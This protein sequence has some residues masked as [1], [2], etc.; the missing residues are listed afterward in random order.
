MCC[1]TLEAETMTVLTFNDFRIKP[2][3]YY[4]HVQSILSKMMSHAD[5]ESK[6]YHAF[7]LAEQV[8]KNL[9]Q[10][11]DNFVHDR[12]KMTVLVRIKN[13]IPSLCSVKNIGK[14]F[15]SSLLV[16]SIEKS[17]KGHLV[18]FQEC[19]VFIPLLK[20]DSYGIAQPF[21]LNEITLIDY[22]DE[23]IL[24]IVPV[25]ESSSQTFPFKVIEKDKT[26]H[27]KAHVHAYCSKAGKKSI[28]QSFVQTQTPETSIFFNFISNADTEWSEFT[29][30]KR[31]AA[32]VISESSDNMEDII[33]K[34]GPKYS[35]NIIDTESMGVLTVDSEEHCYLRMHSDFSELTPN[36]DELN[37]VH[38]M[39]SIHRNLTQGLLSISRVKGNLIGNLSSIDISRLSGYLKEF[40]KVCPKIL[41]RS[42]S[43]Q[44]R[45]KR[46]STSISIH[47]NVSSASFQTLGRRLSLLGRRSSMKL[48]ALDPTQAPPVRQPV[49]LPPRRGT[50][51][52]LLSIFQPKPVEVI[53]AI[54][55][56][57]AKKL[58][59]H[60][61]RFEFAYSFDYSEKV[62]KVYDGKFEA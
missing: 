31:E 36:D 38:D 56:C 4:I 34:I 26:I 37:S 3:Q 54:L 29:N 12:I 7:E 41:R 16:T 62:G 55:K 17:A 32:L 18:L 13:D 58:D 33:G 10:S 15:I 2:V 48:D 21:P 46:G 1:D 20:N 24:T 61:S 43:K 8:S 47:S 27:F 53:S 28:V 6:Q 22:L 51:H 9:I 35:K 60:L 14:L 52:K 25:V 57:V 5:P 50:V 45:H 39:K 30:W 42:K 44:I 49:G 19:L 23:D 11:V 40:E 59:S